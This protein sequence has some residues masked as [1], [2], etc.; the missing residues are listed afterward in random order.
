MYTQY[1]CLIVGVFVL[2]LTE[3]KAVENLSMSSKTNNGLPCFRHGALQLVIHTMDPL[4]EG[5]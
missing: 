5:E 1:S 4:G 2:S 3:Q